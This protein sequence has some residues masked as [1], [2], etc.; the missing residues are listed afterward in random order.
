MKGHRVLGSVI[1]SA[2]A[3]HDFKTKLVSDHAKTISKLAQ[4]AKTAPQKVY[5]A[6]T[7]GMQTKLSFLTRTTP[8]MEEYL[9]EPEELIG[10]SSI[11]S[12]TG[13]KTVTTTDRI[14]FFTG[15]EW[16]PNITL[17]ED[18]NNLRWS[19][20]LGD[21]L[22]DDDPMTAENSQHSIKR[23]IREEKRKC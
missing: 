15:E 7:R 20:S 21:C 19:K 10:E 16:S 22:Y 8:D 4:H 5:Q 18:K 23:A 2:S 12:L 9:Q 11:L 3:C 17:P 14:L 1:G 13:K 6:Y